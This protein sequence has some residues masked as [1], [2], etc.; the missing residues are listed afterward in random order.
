MILYEII[1]NFRYIQNILKTNENNFFRSHK[2]CIPNK[3]TILKTC[4][5]SNII[6]RGKP[7]RTLNIKNK[8]NLQQHY[9]IDSTSTANLGMTESIWQMKD[10]LQFHL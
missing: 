5:S 8:H 6:N 3:N 1:F 7:D 2:K 10:T 9:S 4:N